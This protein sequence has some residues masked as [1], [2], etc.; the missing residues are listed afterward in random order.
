MPVLTLWQKWFYIPHWYW[1]VNGGQSL[2]VLMRMF[3]ELDLVIE[4]HSSVEGDSYWRHWPL[5][6]CGVIRVCLCVCVCVKISRPYR[7]R[8][9]G[10]NRDR[11]NG[12]NKW[13]FGMRQVVLKV[14]SKHLFLHCWLY[15]TKESVHITTSGYSET[16]IRA[17]FELIQCHTH[18]QIWHL[19]TKFDF[20]GNFKFVP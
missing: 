3:V 2:L 20:K 1:N 11:L 19:T 5:K 6:L 15:T 8:R 17:K 16:A 14:R 13:L 10:I 18:S 9:Q 12:T 7:T 4:P